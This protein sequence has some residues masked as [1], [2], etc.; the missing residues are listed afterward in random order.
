M[1]DAVVLTT[2]Q[3]TGHGTREARRL[4]KEGRVPAVLYGHGEATLSLTLSADDLNKAIRHGARVVDITHAGKQEKAL[5]RE[6]QW[7]PLG[8]DILHVDFARVSAHERIT[9]DVRLELRGT[10]PGVIAGGVLDQPLHSL[11]IECPVLSVP[12]VIRVPIGELQ[13]DQAIHVK[14]VKVPPDVTVKNDPEAIVV[15]VRPPVV[16]EE[17]P[18]APAVPGVEAAAEPEVIGRQRPAE[19]EEAEPE[20][21]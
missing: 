20:K 7:D 12:E 17:V 2:Q 1:A 19:E 16:E 4:R 14:D 8:H 15:Q 5:I 21:K 3:R 11:H 9:I 6:V 18:A 13:I 10:A